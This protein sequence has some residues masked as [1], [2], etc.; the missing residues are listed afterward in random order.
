MTTRQIEYL[1]YFCTMIFKNH[2]GNNYR[3][4]DY[5]MLLDKIPNVST[6]TE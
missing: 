6:M 1:R 3:T 4:V 2:I 5:S